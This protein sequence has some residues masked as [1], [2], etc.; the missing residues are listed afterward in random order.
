MGIKNFSSL[1]D[2]ELY[3]IV[4]LSTFEQKKI[5]IDAAII[6][7]KINMVH[8]GI[9]EIVKMYISLLTRLLGANIH[10][11]F[12]FDGIG[13]EEKQHERENREVKR[14]LI[15]DNI[16]QLERDLESFVL[17]KNDQPPSA[18]LLQTYINKIQPKKQ[19]K[20]ETN[21]DECRVSA[22]I[23]GLKKRLFVC[24]KNDKDV[25]KEVLQ[26]FQVPWINAPGEA[27][28]FCTSLCVEKKV[29][30]VFSSDSDAL[31]AGCPLV[32]REYSNN[33]F[34]CIFLENILNHL[35]LTRE[36]W[37][38]VCIMCGTDFNKNLPN[39]GPK[40]A[41]NLIRTFKC[42]ENVPFDTS[43]LN[44][45]RVRQLFV[46]PN[47]SPSFSFSFIHPIQSKEGLKKFLNKFNLCFLFE[48]ITSNVRFR[49]IP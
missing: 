19:K 48:G 43:T 30:A 49:R 23:N 2:P 26:I 4:P 29:H 12:V 24:S 28:M 38:D 46:L 17:H 7:C 11:I 47:V 31:A 6:I 41:L 44:H 40:N 14:T 20:L 42:I 32:I 16:A 21:I 33:G 1:I 15:K 10:P 25:L 9:S 36:Q 35:K 8:E 13:P 45:E 27:E 34:K 22:Y 18:L 3:D 5:A 37:L 39:I